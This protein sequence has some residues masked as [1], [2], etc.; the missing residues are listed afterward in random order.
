M[1]DF[2]LLRKP[3]K[4]LGC[5]F[6]FS[7]IGQ[8]LSIAV[9]YQF[10]FSNL[11]NQRQHLPCSWS[12][13]NVSN[14]T[15]HCLGSFQEATGPV[16]ILWLPDTRV[17]VSA[18]ESWVVSKA[19]VTQPNWKTHFDVFLLVSSL[20]WGWGADTHLWQFSSETRILCF[21]LIPVLLDGPL[22]THSISRCFRLIF[23]SA[24]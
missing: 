22:A 14:L 8:E 15:I 17:N 6:L 19:G 20:H 12:G 5:L 13:C 9:E 18:S 23:L 4:Y 21:I 7:F 3:W 2:R 10:I 16:V 11:G 1:I 24:C